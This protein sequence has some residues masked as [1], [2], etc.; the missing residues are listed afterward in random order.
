MCT[1]EE[2]SAGQR[3]IT[4]DTAIDLAERQRCM[5]RVYAILRE[6]AAQAKAASRDAPREEPQP[7]H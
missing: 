6:I 3:T 4:T 1:T 2:P 7:P 5:S